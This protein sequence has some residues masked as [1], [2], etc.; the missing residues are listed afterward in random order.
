M[1]RRTAR[2]DRIIGLFV[3]GVIL[4]NPPILNLFWG[5]IFGWPA[6]F[7]YLFTAWALVIAGVAFVIERGRGQTESSGPE[8]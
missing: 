4:F 3:L 5:T 6:L 1:L 8:R 2:R 7:L